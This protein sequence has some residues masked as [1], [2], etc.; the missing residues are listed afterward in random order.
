VAVGAH[1]NPTA[2]PIIVINAF[3]A[4]PYKDNTFIKNIDRPE[5]K[6]AY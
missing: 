2:I 5:N 4:F 1:D 6:A 3:M